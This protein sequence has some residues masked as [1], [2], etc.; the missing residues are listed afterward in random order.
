MAGDAVGATAWR[1]SGLGRSCGDDGAGRPAEREEKQHE[2]R[3][4][5]E[6]AP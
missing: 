5:E 4:V 1:R 6:C 3:R 2:E